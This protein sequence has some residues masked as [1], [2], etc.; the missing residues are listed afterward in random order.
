MIL[1]VLAACGGDKPDADAKAP[2]ADMA[3]KAAAPAPKAEMSK[4]FTLADAAADSRRADRAAR[5]AFRH[6]VETL[7]FFGI[8]PDMTVVEV[9]PGGGWYTDILAP[10]LAAGGG[11]LYAAHFDPESESEYM[12]RALAGFK[13]RYGADGD[14][15]G[16]VQLTVLSP[17]APGIAPAGSADLVVTFRN[18]HSFI[19][20]GAAEKYMGDFFAALKP[21]GVLGIVT[22]R[23]P[24]DVEVEGGVRGGYVKTSVVRALAEAAGFEYVASSEVNANPKDTADHPFGVWTLPP[25]SRMPRDGQEAPE[26][27]D[28]EAYKAIGESDRMTLKF[29]KPITADGAL[30]E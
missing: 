26:G 10:Y 19:G 9:N 2:A 1:P 12:R 20:A 18:M 5:D 27:F 14:Y 23:L 24:E 11:T 7:T 30:L 8:E 3:P 16:D 4:E 13:Q 29:R 15:Y 17:T 22:H 28:P 21:G 25:A 6:P